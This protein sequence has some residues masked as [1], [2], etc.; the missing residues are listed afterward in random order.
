MTVRLVK[1]LV[2][3]DTPPATPVYSTYLSFPVLQDHVRV[4]Q[5]IA[6]QASENYRVQFVPDSSQCDSI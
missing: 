5:R 6:K 1:P 4:E 3:M 2:H